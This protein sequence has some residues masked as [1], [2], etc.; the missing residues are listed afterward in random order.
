LVV[1]SIPR[2][3]G[4]TKTPIQTR[5][6][7]VDNARPEERT[8]WLVARYRALAELTEAERLTALRRMI[9]VEYSLDGG[10]RDFTFCR[11]Q[12]WLQLTPDAGLRVAAS[13]DSVIAEMPARIAVTRIAMVQ[14]LI[15]EFEPRQQARLRRLIPERV[16]GPLNF[17]AAPSPGRRQA[18]WWQFWR[19]NGDS[20]RAGPG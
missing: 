3:P 17:S 11:L 6:P 7:W 1:Q 20:A 14:S 10:L 5:R 18:P 19:A 16:T 8:G 15:S 12:A 9:E 2:S 4:Q 13:Y